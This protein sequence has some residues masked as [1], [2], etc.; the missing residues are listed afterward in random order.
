MTSSNSIDSRVCRTSDDFSVIRSDRC[1]HCD[2][3]A[4]DSTSESIPLSYPC[5]GSLSID[6]YPSCSNDLV[7]PALSVNLGAYSILPASPVHLDIDADDYILATDLA[8]TGL[9]LWK[10]GRRGGQTYSPNTE[11]VLRRLR[12]AT[13]EAAVPPAICAI[14]NMVVYLTM[15]SPSFEVLLN[16][17]YEDQITLR[18]PRH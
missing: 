17:T 7:T 15:V 10:L 11:S 13:V 8:I 1:S 4:G 16:E 9:T 12:N 5:V 2:E 14:L 3:S 6:S 18:T